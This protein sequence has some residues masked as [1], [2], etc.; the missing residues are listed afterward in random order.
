MKT[1]RSL[2]L[3][4]LLALL[5]APAV[6]EESAGARLNAIFVADWEHYAAEVPE[7]ATFRGD[8]R[9]NDRLTDA[10]AEAVASRKAYRA[11]L[12][13]K[14]KSIDRAQLSGQDRISYDVFTRDLASAMRFDAVYGNLPF[15]FRDSWSPVTQFVDH[16][17][18]A[19][20]EASTQLA[21]RERELAELRRNIAGKV[22]AIRGQTTRGSR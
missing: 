17:F 4:A 2:G 10:S 18:A 15:S 7:L 14:L 6:G 5:A 12:A 1:S 22:V 8:N 20:Q 9:F 21:R 11:G 3:L 16:Y 19:W 13:A